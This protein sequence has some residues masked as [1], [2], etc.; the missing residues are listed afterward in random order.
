MSTDRIFGFERDFA[1]SLR[2]VP[3]AVRLKLDLCGIKLS[4]RQWSR[5]TTADRQVLLL[6]PCVTPND[7][8]AFSE[9]LRALIDQ[10]CDEPVSDLNEDIGEAAWGNSNFTPPIVSEYALSIGLQPPTDAQWG[11]LAVLQRFALV[12]LTRDRHENIN[13]APALAE[14]GLAQPSL[15]QP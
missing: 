3:M 8:D 12:K 11:S 10:R 7:I 9:D 14:F 5:F 1:S 2:C 15:V 4:L 6:Q 13:F